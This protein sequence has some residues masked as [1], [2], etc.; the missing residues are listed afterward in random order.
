[1]PTLF[2]EPVTEELVDSGNLDL[3]AWLLN[4]NFDYSEPRIR[5]VLA[6]LKANGVTRFA[7]VGFCYGARSGFNLAFE[8]EVAAVIINHPTFLQAPQDFEVRDL[9]MST[10]C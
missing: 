10:C 1:M 8:G 4:N 3:A 5:K 6:A 2:R 9:I 7:V